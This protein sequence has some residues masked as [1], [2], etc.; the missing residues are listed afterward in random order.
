ML[1]DY[2]NVTFV[3]KT[4]QVNAS[5]RTVDMTECIEV[6]RNAAVDIGTLVLFVANGGTVPHSYR[7]RADCD[8]VG[9]LAHPDGHVWVWALRDRAAVRSYGSPMGD[10][11]T[12]V[13]IWGERARTAFRNRNDAAMTTVYR[14]QLA[15]RLIREVSCQSAASARVA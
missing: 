10:E 11:G 1:T 7:Y 13:R 2:S 4:T 8:Y 5:K 14:A 3:A 9:V 12:A 6:A 15:A